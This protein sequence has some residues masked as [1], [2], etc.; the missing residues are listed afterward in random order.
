MYG[1]QVN[2]VKE[3]AAKYD[4]QADRLR[5]TLEAARTEA[6]R[7]AAIL[8]FAMAEDLMLSGL[9]QHLTGEVKGGWSELSGGNGLLATASDRISLL[10]LLNWIHP[11]VYADLRIIKSIR[12]QFA[13][14]PDVIGFEH[15]KI[16]GQVSSIFALEK[17]LVE[18][19]GD[20]V[21]Q[22]LSPRQMYL[23]RAANTLIRLVFNL[24][25][26]PAARR[27]KVAPG[28]IDNAGW[29]KLP[30]NLQELHRILA[31]HVIYVVGLKVQAE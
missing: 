21:D 27:E 25:V 3:E 9:K 8:I 6:D 4:I 22:A 28:H 26:A 12:N 13:H 23:C 17:A 30:D 18:A 14:H 15:Q 2:L 11:T 7:S 10:M 16:R 1:H 24:A 20:G 19:M 31:E 29:E 5:K